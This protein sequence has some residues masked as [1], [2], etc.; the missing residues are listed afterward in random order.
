MPIWVPAGSPTSPCWPYQP[1]RTYEALSTP[2]IHYLGGLINRSLSWWLSG[3]I[4]RHVCCIMSQLGRS[5]TIINTRTRCGCP[6]GKPH[7]EKSVFSVY[8]LSSSSPLIIRSLSSSGISQW[9]TQ[10]VHS[11][12][13]HQEKFR[14]IVVLLRRVALDALSPSPSLALARCE[15]IQFHTRTPHVLI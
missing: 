3:I 1:C 13:C 8:S 15:P 7:S 4:R 10:E 6:A 12:R 5:G 11:V 9:C 14:S 2:V